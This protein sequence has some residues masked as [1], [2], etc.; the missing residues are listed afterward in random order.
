[1]GNRK[2]GRPLTHC[3]G[4]IEHPIDGITFL[5]RSGC[6]GSRQLDAKT[7]YGLKQHV[8]LSSITDMYHS[9]KYCNLIKRITGSLNDR[10]R[11]CERWCEEY[12]T[13][14]WIQVCKYPRWYSLSR[15]YRQ[16]LAFTVAWS[17]WL[18]YTVRFPYLS[19]F[20]RFCVLGWNKLYN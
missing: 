9:K 3:T 16:N 11:D 1:M 5:M 17:W 8:E 12:K 13:E 4:L 7:R 6:K 20:I 19:S 15:R 10:L 18:T 2:R 14:C